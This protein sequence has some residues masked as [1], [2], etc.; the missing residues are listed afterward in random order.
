VGSLLTSDLSV[1]FGDTPGTSYTPAAVVLSATVKS[2]AHALGDATIAL[3]LADGSK[4]TLST[5]VRYTDTPLVVPT[6][7]AA[8][9]QIVSGRATADTIALVVFSGGT[10]EQ[11]V[12]AALAP[13]QC[14]A[15]DRL[16]I[17]A[18]VEGA[19][20]PFIPVAPAQVNAR[21]NQRFS[22]GLPA[23]IALFVRCA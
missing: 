20:I 14:P 21:W 8:P 7:K 17:F 10:S 23:D 5:P 15:K 11:L 4:V 12:A 22:A 18:L 16:I 13:D 3:K 1:L 6:S 19:W 2:P 9:G